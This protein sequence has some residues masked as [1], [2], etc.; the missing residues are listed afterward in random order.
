MAEIKNVF[1]PSFRRLGRIIKDIDLG[2]MR[3]AALQIPMSEDG[4]CQYLASVPG[5]EDTDG[6]RAYTRIYAGGQSIQGGICW[7]YNTK[8]NGVEYHRSSEVNI[9]LDDVV[10]M[11][12]D[13]RD[14][15]DDNTFDSSKM[16]FYFVPAGT[17]V[18]L[19]ATTLH[20]APCQMDAN[21]FR[22]LVFLPKGTNSPL[23]KKQMEEVVAAS[24]EYRLLFAVDKWSI[25][26]PGD[27]DVAAGA[28]P[29]VKGE[30]LE[31]RPS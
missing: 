5:I 27:K 15:E 6:F 2:G 31:Y 7:G 20:L 22:V 18:E 16:E 1:Y 11:L 25:V 17:A 21:G 12:G 4:S 24:G 13:R 9:A 3:E 19:Y 26:Y 23:S 30:V 8:M 28:F 10:M 14:I 29:G